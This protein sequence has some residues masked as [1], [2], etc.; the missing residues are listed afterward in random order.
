MASRQARAASRASRS[1]AASSSPAFS[2][3]AAKASSARASNASTASQSCSRK[4]SRLRLKRASKAEALD[5]K[6]LLA[7]AQV[8]A[9]HLVHHV[10]L[11]AALVHGDVLLHGEGIAGEGHV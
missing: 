10:H 5:I 3:I 11:L 4:R 8:L 9:G 7:L 2:S 6:S 1:A